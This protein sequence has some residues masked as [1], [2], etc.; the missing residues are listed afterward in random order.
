MLHN[1]SDL[2]VLANK[3]KEIRVYETVGIAWQ[4]GLLEKDYAA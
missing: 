4:I 2:R 1:I 3:V